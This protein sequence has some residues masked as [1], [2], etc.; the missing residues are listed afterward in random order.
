MLKNLSILFV[1]LAVVALP[2]LFRGRDAATAS[3]AR[4]EDAVT[5]VIVTPHNEAI[6]YEFGRGFDRWHRAR[7]AKPVQIE[8]RVIGGTTEISR[9][10]TSE[11]AAATKA[12]WTQTLKRDW[13]ARATETVTADKPPAEPE[14]LDVYKTFRATDNPDAVTSLIDLFFGGGQF[15]HDV[16]F[17]QGLT[18]PPWNPGEEPKNLFATDAGVPLIPDKLSGET[19]RTP[20]LFGNVISTFGICYNVDRLEDLGVRRPPATWDDLADPVYFAQVG[21]V[22]PSKSGSVAKAFEMMIHQKVYQAVRAAAF[23][24]E[25]IAAFEKQI[26]EFA[27]S[28]GPAYQR[29]DLPPAVP[30][31]YQQAVERGWTDGVH[32]VQRIGANARYFTDSASKAPIDV[33]VGDAAVAMSIDFYGRYQAQNSR[34]PAGEER[35]LYLTPAGGSSVSC[36]PISLLRGAGGAADDP[37]LAVRTRKRQEQR[38]VAIRFIEFVLSEDGQ[39]LW[40]YKP[41]TPGGPEKF[42]L[43]RLPIRRDFYPSTN[44]AIQAKHAEHAKHAADNLADPAVDPFKLAQQFTYHPRWTGSHFSFQRELV[45]VMCVDAGDELKEA[46]QGIAKAGGPA[47]QPAAMARLG[48]MPN[49]TLQLKGSADRE[50]VEVNWR[51]AP[52]ISKKYDRLDYTRAWTIFF[53]DNYRAATKEVK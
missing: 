50:P 1:L 17:R 24:D 36:D 47:R 5:L 9:Y 26:V 34:G 20:T 35:M 2:F 41:G 10:L 45:R 25:Q 49:V 8:W 15:D 37:D 33:S 53:R 12:W 48:R 31:A 38:A 46:W 23:T 28:R 3:A 32:L 42:A 51:T 43:R 19:W 29:G 22:D 30:P 6:R 39:R 16:A 40:T 14:L 13:P 7:F 52:D 21:A 11:Y 4:D 27:K 18:V 44:P